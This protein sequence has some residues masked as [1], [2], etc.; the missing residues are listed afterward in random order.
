VV[1]NSKVSEDLLL[2][3]LRELIYLQTILQVQFQVLLHKE[4]AIIRKIVSRK[5]M[6]LVLAPNPD[7][8]VKIGLRGDNLVKFKMEQYPLNQGEDK[9]CKFSLSP[10][11]YV[12]NTCTS[13]KVKIPKIHFL[14]LESAFWFLI[15]FSIQR[16]AL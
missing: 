11:L 7:T 12:S 13:D 1:K 15:L 2:L 4:G 5:I 6:T 8:E 10:I 14:L 16:E 9:S 3:D